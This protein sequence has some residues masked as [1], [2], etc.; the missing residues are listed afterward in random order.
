MPLDLK[1]IHQYTEADDEATFSDLLNL[2][3]G[4]I[5]DAMTYLSGPGANRDALDPAPAGAMW[6]D[7]DG[8]QRLYSTGPDGKWRLHEGYASG[9]AASWDL[10]GAS[11]PITLYVRTVIVDIPTVL[12]LDETILVGHAPPSSGFTFVSLIGHTR[13]ADRTTLSLRHMI[14]QAATQT[15]CHFTWR[16]VKAGL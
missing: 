3:Q 16:I 4:S 7:T 11:G 14:V 2:G 15:A 6:Q 9:P 10:G 8:D 13:H 5:S 1:G 12:A